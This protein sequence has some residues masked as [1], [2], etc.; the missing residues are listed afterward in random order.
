MAPR[1]LIATRTF[2]STSEE[3]WRILAEAGLECDR[4]DIKTATDEEMTAAFAKADAAIVGGRPIT[5][6]M[7]EGAPHLKVIAMHGVGVSHIDRATTLAKGIVVANAP[8]A[9]SS[10]VAD[11]TFGLML[12]VLRRIPQQVNALRAGAWTSEVGVELWQKTL[13]IVGLGHIGRD[14]ARRAHGFDMTVLAYD[15]IVSDE[16]FA[17]AE[18]RSVSLE[19]LL[20]ASDVVTLHAPSTPAT[21]G[22]INAGRLHSMKRNACLINTARGDLVDEDAL[23]EALTTGVIAGAGLD[24]YAQEPPNNNPLLTLPNVVATPHIGAHTEEAV[25]RA[26]VMSAQNVVGVLR[27]GAAK[28]PVW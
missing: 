1:V 21:K 11:L 13:G 12:A 6:A 3:P 4:I 8:G 26:S 22:L 7:V 19:D 27:T 23:Y 9:N 14:V 15:P 17:A 20:A 28:W 5:A 2:G 25:T 18:A 24:A 10:S 16:A